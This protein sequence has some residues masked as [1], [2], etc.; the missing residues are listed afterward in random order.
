MRRGRLAMWR[1]DLVENL[2]TVK[3]LLLIGLDSEGLR[4]AKGVDLSL[5]DLDLLVGV[6][7]FRTGGMVWGLLVAL[8]LNVESK[9]TLIRTFEIV[10]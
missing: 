5:E 10:G 3:L 1:S 9:D 7:D 8:R 6:A 2:D 4:F